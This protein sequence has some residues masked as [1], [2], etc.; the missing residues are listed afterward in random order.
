MDIKGEPFGA[1]QPNEDPDGDGK[2]FTL[3]LRFPGQRVDSATGLYQNDQRDYD[4]KT[5]RYLQSDP[6]GLE[7]GINPY[8]YSA[9][10]PFSL[11]DP[12]GLAYFAYR[13]L[14]QLPWLG[15]FSN[16]PIDNALHTSISHEQLFFEDGKWPENLGFFSDTKLK[17][18]SRINLDK[19]H[20]LLE[21]ISK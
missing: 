16:N 13:P 17:E 12:N 7:G 20:P 2:A 15:P 14:G 1:S 4:P 11:I 18:D 21:P 3:D 9:N 5:G 19:Y 10:N 8:S 6:I